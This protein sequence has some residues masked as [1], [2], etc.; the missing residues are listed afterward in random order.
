MLRGARS[1][2]GGRTG[3][4]SRRGGAGDRARRAPADAEVRRSTASR[5]RVQ[6]VYGRAGHAVQ[7]LRRRRE[8]QARGPGRRQPPAVLVPGMPDADPRRPQGRRPDRARQHARVLRRRAGGRRRHDRVRRPARGPRD[9]AG[10]AAACSRHDYTHD[11]AEAPSLEEG[12]AHL[13]RRAFDGVELDVDLKLAGY[14]DR[15][16]AALRERGLLDRTL[17]SSH[18]Q[19]SLRRDPRAGPGVALGWSVP[20]VRRDYTASWLYQA[21]RRCRARCRARGR[22]RAARGRA[23]RGPLRRDHG[24]TGGSSPRGWCARSRDAGGELYA[25]TVDDARADRA[26]RGAGRHRGHHQRPA[27][28]RRLAA[29]SQVAALSSPPGRRPR[30]ERCPASVSR[31]ARR[32]RSPSLRQRKRTTPRSVIGAA[33]RLEGEGPARLDRRRCARAPSVLQ[34]ES[35]PFDVVPL[36]VAVLVLDA[37]A[38]P[39]PRPARPR[40]A[41]TPRM[42]IAFGCAAVSQTLIVAHR[43]G[44]FAAGRSPRCGFGGLGGERRQRRR[45]QRIGARGRGERATAATDRAGR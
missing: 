24:S 34:P 15:V 41:S 39:A 13:A 11:V 4:V 22:S 30:V 14:E 36:A 35:A 3:D 37:E 7:A 5:T 31:C 44:G 38:H 45:D 26:A 29:I 10:S 19:R 23:A 43:S 12:L 9:R 42:P 6:E 28:V 20:K 17:I 33:R 21:P 32:R 16:V 8:I 25:W 1:T 27:P 40:P 18:G 2:R